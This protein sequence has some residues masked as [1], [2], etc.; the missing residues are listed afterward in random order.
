MDMVM[1][2]LVIKKKRKNIK[3]SRLSTSEKTS[4]AFKQASVV[5]AIIW[6]QSMAIRTCLSANSENLHLLN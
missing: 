1:K 3:N 5:L 2:T 4:S 6:T